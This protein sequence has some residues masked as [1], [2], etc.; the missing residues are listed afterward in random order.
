MEIEVKFRID[1]NQARAAI[2]SLGADFVREELQEDLY[3]SLP[4]HELLRVRR[5]S[6]LGRSFL[7][8]KRI[9][10]PGRNEEFDEIEVEVSDFDGTVEIL[11]RLGFREDIWI[12]KRRLVY[13]LDGVTFEL[14]EVEGLGAFLDI[15][16]ISDNVEE[17]KRRIWEIA[18][19]LGLTE[20]D[21]EPRL[22]QE[23]I[24]EGKGK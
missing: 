21:V 22:Y 6:N 10:D 1:F 14:N 11:K 8:Y 23:L 2:E 3:F 17:A 4:P 24:R 9:A 12:R 13:R 20:D 5:I 7:T 15:E 16:V 18:K 19:R